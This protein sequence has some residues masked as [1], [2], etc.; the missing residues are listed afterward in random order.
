MS[1]P[2]D[3]RGGDRRDFFR[4]VIGDWVERLVAKAEDTVIQKRY[5]RPP[6]ALPEVGFLTACTRCGACGDACP[7]HA[8]QFA[9]ASAGLAAGTPFY[10]PKLQPCIACPDMPCVKACPTGRADRAGGRLG[11]LPYRASWS[12]SPSAASPS[13]APSAASASTPARSGPRRWR[14]TRRVTRSF[15]PKGAWGAGSVCGSA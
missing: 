3:H 12:C 13:R 7:P 2:W 6:G 5:F 15:G 4:D 11:W 9:A 10:D 1:A 8:I 14:W